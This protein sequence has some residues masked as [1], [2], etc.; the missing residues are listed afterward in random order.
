ME[1]IRNRYLLMFKEWLKD[2]EFIDKADKGRIMY[3][4]AE[5]FDDID[6]LYAIMECLNTK[7]GEDRDSSERFAFVYDDEKSSMAIDGYVIS[8]DNEIWK[9][10]IS[11]MIDIFDNVYPVGTVVTLR[12]E[13]FSE[14]LPV[15]RIEEL[16][17]VINHRLFRGKE[18]NCFIN[19]AG[20]LYPCGLSLNSNMLY[21][22]NK[23]IESVLY[24]GYSDLSEEAYVYH[25]KC[26]LILEEKRRS[27]SFL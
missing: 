5:I 22:S 21:F 19:Y 20:S 26:N 17:V 9:S 11:A 3:F 2:K 13:Y 12:K 4:S 18:D 27:I 8:L 6:F 24:K 23:A 25:E 14:V 15:D 1:T 7:S 10:I 16:K